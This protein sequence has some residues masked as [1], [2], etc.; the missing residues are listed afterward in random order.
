M[1]SLAEDRGFKHGLTSLSKMKLYM[2]DTTSFP[3]IF[4]AIQFNGM[5][6]VSDPH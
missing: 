6:E 1:A 5:C 3:E 2:K 4:E